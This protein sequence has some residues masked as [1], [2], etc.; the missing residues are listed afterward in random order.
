MLLLVFVELGFLNLNM[1]NNMAHLFT[2]VDAASSSQSE[3]ILDI[4]MYSFRRYYI[5]SVD[6][7]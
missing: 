1:G 7:G 2:C 4:D 3:R 6:V 5:K